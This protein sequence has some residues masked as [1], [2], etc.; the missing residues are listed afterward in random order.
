MS[1]WEKVVAIANKAMNTEAQQI[2]EELR[3]ECPKRTGKTAASFHIIGSDESAT[4]S[5]GGKGLV[6]R[7]EVGSTELSALYANDGNIKGS[8][9]GRI[10]PSGNR[11]VFTGSKAP[12][13]GKRY[14]LPSVKAYEGTH[15]VEKVA[16]RHR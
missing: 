14:S 16:N 2:L 3:A 11:L 6:T 10:Y 1:L 7:I 12:Y 13:K 8:I 9:G 15:F 5:T 4:V